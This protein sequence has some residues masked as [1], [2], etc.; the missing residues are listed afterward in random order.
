MRFHRAERRCWATAAAGLG[1][2]LLSAG[3]V[4]G[5]TAAPAGAAAQQDCA[6]LTV[7][8]ARGTGEP[9]SGSLLLSS[10]ADSIAAD[11]GVNAEVVELEYPAS[12]S[13]LSSANEGITTLVE[14]LNDA[15][16]SCPSQQTVLLGY[17]QGGGVVG[18]ALADPGDRSVGSF[19]PALSEQAAANVAAVAM[20]GDMSFNGGDPFNAG[21]FDAGSDGVLPRPDGSLDAVADRIVSFCDSD[22]FACQGGPSV[23]AHIGYFTNGARGE[24]EQFVAER[25]AAAGQPV[26]VDPEL[27]DPGALDPADPGVVDP[28]AGAGEEIQ[29]DLIPEPGDI[30]PDPDEEQ[31]GGFS[32]LDVIGGL[33]P[34]LG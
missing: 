21:S 25:L 34:G 4:A 26:A 33:I 18:N 2:A 6:D 30:L 31:G 22:D 9:Q 3:A 28:G 1:L 29:P 23:I 32:F 8:S 5:L 19:A 13:I 16:V 15:A 24:A 10:T 7:I 20:F 11:S 27:V 17:S 14:M 12:A